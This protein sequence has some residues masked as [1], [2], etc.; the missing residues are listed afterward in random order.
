[1]LPVAE[2][3]KI[4]QEVQNGAKKAHVAKKYGVSATTV[5]NIYK[6]R[7]E[8]PKLLEK[9]HNKKR[10]LKYDVIDRLMLQWFKSMREKNMPVTGP[11]VIEMAEKFAQ[12]ENLDGFPDSVGWLDK[13]K[14]R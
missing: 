4:V 12:D 10:V 7:D 5:G 6:N 14:K 11:M 1:M 2:K 13:F 3:I 8:L 9:G